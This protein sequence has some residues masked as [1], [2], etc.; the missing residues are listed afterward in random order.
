[1][2]E[3]LKK[4]FSK[5]LNPEIKLHNNNLGLANANAD[6]KADVRLADTMNMQF[7]N[8]YQDNRNVTIV[9]GITYEDMQVCVK[10]V[11]NEKIALLKADLEEKLLPEQLNQLKDNV[12]VI[13]SYR[14]AIS[15][16]A[17][18]NDEDFDKILSATLKDRIASDDTDYQ[19]T[20]AQA[21]SIIGKFTKNHL[22]LLSL[23]Y[24]YRSNHLKNFTSIEQFM[25]FYNQYIVQLVDIPLDNI[26]NI[27]LPI[28]ANGCAVTY[29]FGSDFSN[30]FN[31]EV[32]A[33]IK[34]LASGKPLNEEEL[35]QK[36]AIDKLTKIWNDSRLTSAFPTPVGTCIGNKYLKDI[37][38]LNLNNP[39]NDSIT[40]NSPSKVTYGDI[41]RIY[42][43]E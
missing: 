37:L 42:K 21:I 5:I 2:I 41:G 10:A 33:A 40:P 9:Q 26:M 7:G 25:D 43:P 20:C 35:K 39:K 17:M 31:K 23:F 4:V 18:K 36:N 30:F 6:I 32:K 3:W 14:E 34:E 11:I 24:I 12:G 1:M 15:I 38:F 27:G 22:K 28:I 16:S 29:T 8:T 13:A 19:N